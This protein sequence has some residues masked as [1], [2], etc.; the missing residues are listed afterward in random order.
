MRTE[1]DLMHARRIPLLLAGSLF[2]GFSL[3]SEAQNGTKTLNGFNISNALVPVGEI[4][5]GGPPRDGIPSIDRPDFLRPRQVN[6]LTDDDLVVGVTFDGKTR[7]YPLRILVQHEIVNDQIGQFAFLVTYCP[8]CG[9]AMVFDRSTGGRTRSFGVSGLLYLSDVLMYDRESESLFS[10]LGMKAVAGP[11]A[12]T[13]LEWLPSEHMTWK[14]WR[15]RYPN[16]EVLSN[17]SARNRDYTKN[18]YE[19]YDQSPNAAVAVPFYRSDLPQKSWIL[20]VIVAGQA[21][22]YAVAQLPPNQTITE[23][24][25]GQEIEI[26]YDSNSRRTVVVRSDTGE[27]IPSVMAYWFAWQAFYPETALW[28]PQD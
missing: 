18:P 20:G 25:G 17:R 26:A 4:R 19:G 12:G 9:A 3:R 24:V 28:K 13:M 27:A 6:Y 22:A 21:K 2:L 1:T 10:Q 14:A 7:A 23:I 16:G 11:L 5:S 15:Q 8:L